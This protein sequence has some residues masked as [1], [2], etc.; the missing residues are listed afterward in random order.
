MYT[1]SCCFRVKTWNVVSK[2]FWNLFWWQFVGHCLLSGKND[3]R[4]DFVLFRLF[5]CFCLFFQMPDDDDADLL[6]P[7]KGRSKW[8]HCE[9]G[10][11]SSNAGCGCYQW[12]WNPY[13]PISQ[14]KHHTQCWKYNSLREILYWE[15]YNTCRRW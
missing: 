11:W 8:G 4:L 3:D 7:I 15:Q 10:W 1:K 2:R 13:W 12:W 14:A 9:R 6:I 5:L